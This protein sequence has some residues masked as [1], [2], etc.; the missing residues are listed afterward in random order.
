MQ[1]AEV[2][3][4]E[5]HVAE[6]DA[7]KRCDFSNRTV[8]V[9]MLLLLA[10][11]VLL[12]IV[13]VIMGRKSGG[14]V[15]D[16]GSDNVPAPSITPAQGTDFELLS[17]TWGPGFCVV[18]GCNPA[19]PAKGFSI[20]GLWP[21]YNVPRKGPNGVQEFGPQNCPGADPFNPSILTEELTQRMQRLWPS[22]SK[23]G[24]GLSF[25]QH[26]WEKHGT[27]SGMTQNAY[28][29]RT[30]DQAAMVTPDLA[31]WMGLSPT[32]DRVTAA[33]LLDNF[34]KNKNIPDADVALTCSYDKQTSRVILTEVRMCLSA[35]TLQ[36]Q[37]CDPT[38]LVQAQKSCGTSFFVQ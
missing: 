25:W 7:K 8:G 14:D 21:N 6:V 11:C 1:E 16:E 19:I 3:V 12:I 28:F 37:K 18:P 15:L 38:W 24:Q 32:P 36:Y 17:L 9:I 13:S 35:T 31:S 29:I 27:C 22:L 2:L 30:M 34:H 20:H 23:S 33:T 10:V 5:D 4:P 26:E